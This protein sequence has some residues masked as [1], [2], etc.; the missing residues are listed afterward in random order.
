MSRH[1]ALVQLLRDLKL[2]DYQFTVV[3]PAT[4]A[5]VLAREAAGPPDLRAIF[6]WN[7]LFVPADLEPGLLRLLREA[8]A[9]HEAPD[10]KLKSLV[11]IA[12]LEGELFLHS[13]FPT[14]E[15]DA[16][17]FGP[18]TY[19]FASFVRRHLGTVA[20][21]VVDM[22]AGS[23]AGGITV[24]KRSPHA[25]VTLVDVND[26]ALRLAA[27]NA[28][29]AG[30]EVELLRSGSLP[31][32]ADLVIANPPYIMDPGARTYR[33]GG[34]LLG[35]A[36]ALDWVRQFLRAASPGARMLLYTGAAYADGRSPLLEAIVEECASAGARWSFE[37]I[38]PDVFG[39][40]LGEPAYGQV[41]RIA[42]VGV[43]IDR[44]RTEDSA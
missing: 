13:A 35:G 29:A 14:N 3:T 23:G 7:R 9:L 38:D 17:F 8:D 31:E 25:R 43:V 2:R 20:G 24:G 39:E 19:R 33:D 44:S 10:G 37:E 42:A 4:H 15:A 12:A 36:V 34:E 28:E 41:E 30:V 32:S 1:A 21:R 11:R 26:R 22:G 6:G 27:A 16:V 18:D 5:R 40:E